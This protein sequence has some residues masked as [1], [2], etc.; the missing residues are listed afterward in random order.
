MRIENQYT[1]YLNKW[2][3]YFTKDEAYDYRNRIQK[4]IDEEDLNDIVDFGM[5][6]YDEDRYSIYL[7]EGHE[8]KNKIMKSKADIYIKYNAIINRMNYILNAVGLS[9]KIE[10]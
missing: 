10:S 5:V 1:F 6:K 2:V 9:D 3:K 8:F 4:L 7:R